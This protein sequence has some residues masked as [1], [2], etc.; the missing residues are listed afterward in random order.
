MGASVVLKWFK[1]VPLTDALIVDGFYA[2][3]VSLLKIIIM[4]ILWSP[5]LAIV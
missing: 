3:Y 2:H 5:Q 1:L 4:P